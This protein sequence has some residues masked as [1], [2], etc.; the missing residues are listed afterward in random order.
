MTQDD[1][2]LLDSK[3]VIID[4]DP[5]S[6]D[7]LS[8]MLEDD[9]YTN[10]ISFTGAFEGLDYCLEN[11]VDLIL[12]DIQM[13][14]ING[15]G[16]LEKLDAKLHEE[17]LPVIVLTAHAGEEVQEKALKSGAH[18]FLTKPFKQNEVLLRIKNVLTTRKYY[19]LAV[20]PI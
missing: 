18:D 16:V 5:S 14:E 1:E 13:P 9:D 2:G 15:I 8:L 4:D 7:L 3:I 11:P 6:V 10:V 19:K 12:L 20:K 17:F